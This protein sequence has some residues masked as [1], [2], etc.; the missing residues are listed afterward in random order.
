MRNVRD[1]R[2]LPPGPSRWLA[3]RQP[4]LLVS[5]LACG[6]AL[7]R[8]RGRAVGVAALLIA[9]CWGLAELRASAAVFGWLAAHGVVTGTI[10][11]SFFAFPRMRRRRRISVQAATE[12]LS[13][14]P[15]RS[16]ALPPG[17]LSAL[18]CWVALIALTGLAWVGG[19]ID[20]A[21]AAALVRASAGGA[22]AGVA[23]AAIASRALGLDAPGSGYAAV[24]PVRPEWARAPSLRPLSYWPVAQGRI[25]SRPKSLARVALLVLLCLPMGTPGQAMIAIAAA[26]MA[27]FTLASLSLASARVS[28]EAARW[29]APSG[30]TG[31][32]FVPALQWRALLKQLLGCIVLVLL[33]ELIGPPGSMRV[34]IPAC[35]AML[36]ASWTLTALCCA[37]ACRRAGL[38]SAIRAR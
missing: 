1:L 7:R 33:V 13:A 3:G 36:L 6:N 5:A 18:V 11:A 21:A 8:R 15:L 23:A 32:R 22:F 26:C 12:W 14:L 10:V 25:F 34:M 4:A 24:R 31:R 20:A 30:V 38:G 9:C 16:R 37:L 27:V 17:W 35:L 29:L 28:F 2:P 19:R